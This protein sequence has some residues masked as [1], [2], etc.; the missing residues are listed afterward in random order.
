MIDDT[1][2][3]Q[4]L[5]FSLEW[6]PERSV[7]LLEKMRRLDPQIDE[8]TVAELG[9][10]ADEIQSYAWRQFQAAFAKRISEAEAAANIRK[11]FPFVSPENMSH[12]RTQGMYY[13]WKG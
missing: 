1:L 7:P 11:K 10:L 5:K 4:A 6:G 2:R 3:N 12:L 13:A 9:K 8:K